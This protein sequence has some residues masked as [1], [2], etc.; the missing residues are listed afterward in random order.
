MGRIGEPPNI[1]ISFFSRTPLS[2]WKPSVPPQSWVGIGPRRR[3]PIHTGHTAKVPA[4]E[5]RKDRN[6]QKL[7]G[8]EGVRIQSF[9]EWCANSRDGSE[10]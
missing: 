7:D 8:R 10:D 1:P 5:C 2:E 4:P 9:V 6:S 3:V